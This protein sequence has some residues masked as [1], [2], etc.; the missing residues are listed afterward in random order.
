MEKQNLAQKNTHSPIKT[1]ALQHKIYTNKLKPGLVASYNIRP[2]NGEGLFWFRSFINPENPKS[3]RF[4]D[5]FGRIWIQF[6][7]SKA[8][9]HHSSQSGVSR[10][11]VNKYALN[12]CLPM[13][14]ETKHQM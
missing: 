6:S 13:S 12:S 1:N 5:S 14:V 2:G 4:S 11:K 8:H 10:T 9:V 7:F 3:N